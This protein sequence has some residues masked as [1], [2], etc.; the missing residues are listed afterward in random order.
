[1]HPESFL[2]AFYFHADKAKVTENLVEGPY[3]LFCDFIS[4]GNPFEKIAE[5]KA[6]IEK[7]I[8]EKM[9]ASGPSELVIKSALFHANE[10][11]FRWQQRGSLLASALI[12]FPTES[13]LLIAG[14]GDIKLYEASSAEL[15]PCFI[16]PLN[17]ASSK[18]LSVQER[19]T[20]MQN[21]LGRSPSLTPHLLKLSPD[22]LK[23]FLVCSYGCYQLA[24]LPSIQ[25]MA[26]KPH[27]PKLGISAELLSKPSNSHSLFAALFFCQQKVSSCTPLSS[28][29]DLPSK[30][31][32]KMVISC[33]IA[34]TL[35]IAAIAAISPLGNIEE[36]SVNKIPNEEASPLSM[37]ALTF[38]EASH[39]LEEKEQQISSLKKMVQ[40]YQNALISS[41]QEHSA[42][43]QLHQEVKEQY[44]EHVEE[45]SERLAKQSEEFEKQLKLT[46]D[47]TEENEKAALQI[48][49][50]YEE[51]KQKAFHAFKELEKV[52]LEK[53][54]LASKLTRLEAV[55]QA[56]IKEKEAERVARTTH[57]NEQ[58]VY[59]SL[60]TPVSKEMILHKVSAGDTL[61]SISQKY[62]G[63]S[64]R[65][66]EIY[67]ANKEIIP[68]QNR[69]KPGLTLSIP[70]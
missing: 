62:Y 7:A 2:K 29:I 23:R 6:L 16:D 59:K 58:A 40:H 43:Q 60:S 69:L 15:R 11:F 12:I 21:A 70:P 66:V 4:L 33:T 35:I 52:N 31:K 22:P 46:A 50:A 24:S 49:K 19:H 3:L 44:H 51:L 8:D 56:L 37:V 55:Q 13:S 25:E 5:A 63:T 45:L 39:L 34:A 20:R 30:K 54:F 32:R 47:K 38:A 27:D 61:S 9:K 1:M 68:N 14:V 53:E 18:S 26:L 65:W 57:T 17:R 48:I 64:K 42:L 36:S 10:V 28:Q 41:S 67:E